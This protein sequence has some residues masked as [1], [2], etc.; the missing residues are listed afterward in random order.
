MSSTPV[1]V[2]KLETSR[3]GVAAFNFQI[4]L[5]KLPAGRYVSQASVIDENGKKF[6]FPRNSIVVLP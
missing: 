6:S 5:A 1:R 4:P 2:S 3:P